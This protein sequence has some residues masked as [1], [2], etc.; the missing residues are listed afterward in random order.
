[1]S[2]EDLQALMIQHQQQNDSIYILQG[3]LY[4]I[5][6]ESVLENIIQCF[7][8]TVPPQAIPSSNEDHQETLQTAQQ[9]PIQND[10]PMSPP[11][12]SNKSRAN[13]MRNRRAQD[14]PQTAQQRRVKN[15]E[16]MR[17]YRKQKAASKVNSNSKNV[18]LQPIDE[19]KKQNK[20]GKDCA[21]HR[22]AA[23]KRKASCQPIHSPPSVAVQEEQEE[24][25][26]HEE[27][28][29]PSDVSPTDEA[30][31][32][33]S[34]PPSSFDVANYETNATQ[35]LLLFHAKSASA[36][37]EGLQKIPTASQ[38]E[39]PI[40]DPIDDAS[41]PIHDCGSADNFDVPDGCEGLAEE[42]RQR[43]ANLKKA[44]AE[45]FEKCTPQL[46]L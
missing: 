20:I 43:A 14:C 8:N 23:K 22:K 34:F 7:N 30:L 5:V 13:Y 39:T 37:E 3:G 26:P 4:H 46:L 19:A 40:D 15:T 25:E 36:G 38:V 27:N 10:K 28:F 33:R 32:Y 9:L 18:D 44:Q 45:I 2:L 42:L 6:D 31:M 29:P 41:Q 17:N 35:A 16:Y 24:E 1:M 11:N 21:K 12:K